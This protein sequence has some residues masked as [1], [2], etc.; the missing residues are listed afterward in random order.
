MSK[1]DKNDKNI[2]EAYIEFNKQ[3]IIIISGLPG[4]G[5]SNFG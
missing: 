3:L 5:K 2:V 1:N 4:C